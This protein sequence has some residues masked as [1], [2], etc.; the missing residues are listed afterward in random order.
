MRYST[1]AASAA[2][3]LLSACATT[4]PPKPPPPAHAATDWFQQQMQQ[5]RDARRN[6]TPKSDTDGAQAA[7]TQIV[8][9]ACTRVA[10]SGPDKYRTQC[11]AVLKPVAPSAP[12]PFACNNPN[13]DPETLT[14][15]ND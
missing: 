11:D 10:L 12:D 4:P 14:A 9:N 6:H 2:V 3:L 5:A 15:C 1:I 8:R 13:A 7:Y